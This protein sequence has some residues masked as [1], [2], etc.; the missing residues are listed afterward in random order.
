M[1]TAQSHSE[2]EASLI[3]NLK[4]ILIRNIMLICEII[5]HILKDMLISAL[6]L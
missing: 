5:N 4:K 6:I 3:F 2:E 1:L